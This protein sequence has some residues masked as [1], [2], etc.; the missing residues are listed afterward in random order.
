ML[1]LLRS[2]A[3]APSASRGSRASRNRQSQSSSM[4]QVEGSGTDKAT[5]RKILEFWETAGF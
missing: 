1:C 4:A 2:R 5:E 3:L